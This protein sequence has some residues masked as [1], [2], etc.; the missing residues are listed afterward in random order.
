M[1]AAKS[2]Y[3]RVVCTP[4]PDFTSFNPGFCN[5]PRRVNPF[6]RGPFAGACF[7]SGSA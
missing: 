3:N 6:L 5:G 4:F 1:S 2:G 7:C